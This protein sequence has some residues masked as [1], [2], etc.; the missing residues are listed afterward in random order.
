M[1]NQA[2]QRVIDALRIPRSA[3]LATSGPAGLQ[4]SEF[5]CQADGLDLY[6]LLP[7]TSDHLFNLEQDHSVSLLTP[8]WEMKGEARMLAF[9]QAGRALFPEARAA[10]AGEEWYILVRVAPRQMQIRREGAQPGWGNLETIDLV[11]NFI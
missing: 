7:K 11:N 1:L 3:V 9:H 4:V 10:P 2:R 5:P 8:Q 6:L